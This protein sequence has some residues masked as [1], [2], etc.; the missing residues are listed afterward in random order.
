MIVNEFN[1]KHG[2]CSL[3]IESTEDLWV[4]RRLIAKGDVVVTRSSRVVK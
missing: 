2:Y 4:L 3:T 1:P